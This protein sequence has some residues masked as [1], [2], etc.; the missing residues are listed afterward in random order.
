MTRRNR[1]LRPSVPASAGLVAMVFALGIVVRFLG[2]EAGLFALVLAVTALVAAP[3]VYL[4]RGERD[5]DTDRSS[6]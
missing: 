1:R 2:T 3:H 4:P 6:L 5:T